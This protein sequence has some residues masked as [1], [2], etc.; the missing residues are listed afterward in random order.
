MKI[1]K[2]KTVTGPSVVKGTHLTVITD[3]K[4]KVTLEWD[5]EQLLK[6]VRAALASVEGKPK[7]AAA[8]KAPAKKAVAKKVPA[9]TATKT[10]TK[11]T[12]AKKKA[13]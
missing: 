4:G 3:E 8:K 9:K 10:P 11:K 1:R 2:T 7:K 5:D 13:K 6:E 12:V